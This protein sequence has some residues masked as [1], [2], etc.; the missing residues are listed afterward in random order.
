[1]G[2]RVALAGCREVGTW[3]I[4]GDG[5]KPWERD[6]K[7]LVDALTARGATVETPAW[8]DAVDWATY[9]VVVPRSTWDYH[10]H[11]DRFLAWVDHT[12]SVTRLVNPPAVLRW[13][14]HKAYLRE[15][16]VPQP[17]TR[18]LRRGDDLEAL[19]AALPWERGFLKPA[20]GATAEGTL[21]F[22]AAG[23]AEAVAHA[24]R[25]LERVDELLAQPYLPTVETLGERSAVVVGGRVAHWVRKL[26]V[27]GDYR[28]QDDYGATDAPHEP[29][30]REEALVREVLAASAAGVPVAELAYARVD[31]LVAD[32]GEPQLVELE[33]VEPCLF[34]R[35]GPGAAA[36]LADLLLR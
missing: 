1:M 13:N 18:W 21:R 6:D 9:D 20:V 32:D 33:L 28:V 5:P 7:V 2:G 16:R 11:R 36:A 27:A 17:P 23:R 19:I 12:G 3:G 4:G 35:H 10:H 14:T 24:R 30:A 25:W 31:W 15:L 26:P 34:F 8:D 29:S 22:E